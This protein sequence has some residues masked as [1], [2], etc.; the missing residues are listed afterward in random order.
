MSSRVF[1]RETSDRRDFV[2]SVLRRFEK[3]L[4][5]RS[6]FVKPNIVSYEAYPTSTH[7]D[8]LDAVLKFLTSKGN[9]IV[10][11]EGPAPDAGSHSEIIDNH[12]L[13]RVCAKYEVELADLHEYGFRRFLTKSGF[14]LKVSEIPY[15]CDYMIS[16]PVLKS[17]PWT[18]MTGATKNLFGLLQNRERIMMHTRIKNIHR[19]IAELHSAFKANL[20]IMD[21]VETLI[22]ANEVRHGGERKRLGYMLAGEDPLA[23]DSLGLHLLQDVDPKLKDKKPL[24]IKHLFWMRKLG[25]GTTEY[26][27]ARI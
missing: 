4:K 25:L 13:N 21:G 16:L 8:V 12:P 24:E 3:E 19:G 15:E 26:K 7:R 11:G 18:D 14:R 1:I 20:T 17:H 22:T 27:R 6:V 23:L 9:E 2:N 5:G 10:V